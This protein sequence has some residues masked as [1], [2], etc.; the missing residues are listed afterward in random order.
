MNEKDPQA[1]VGTG[2]PNRERSRICEVPSTSST[3]LL[4]QCGLADAMRREQ[5]LIG[6]RVHDRCA[7]RTASFESEAVT[8]HV[9][10]RGMS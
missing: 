7:V 6:V 4:S 1:I 2:M 10:V 9:T 8:L 3:F 5:I